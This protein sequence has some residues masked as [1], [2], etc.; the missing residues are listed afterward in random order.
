MTD[1]MTLAKSHPDTTVT[2]K[3][4]DLMRFH[5]DITADL[6]KRLLNKLVEIRKDDR[7]LSINQ[8]CEIFSIDRSTLWK[9]QQK[10][11]LVPF[12]AG[13]I[14]RYKLSEIR[15]RINK[16]PIKQTNKG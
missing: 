16:P 9:W 6:E 11:L 4:K 15:A 5:E 8:V 7:Y 1:L 3:L 13:T 12:K 2:V 14:C 10:G